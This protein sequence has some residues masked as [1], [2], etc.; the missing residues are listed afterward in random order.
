F[1]AILASPWCLK[2][3]F[4]FFSD[5]LPLA[6]Y[7]R[8]SYLIVASLVA[9]TSFFAL[10]WWTPWPTGAYSELL[11][12]LLVPTVAVIF[13]NV[14]VDAMMIEAGQPRGI[15]G[16]LQS[17][18][19]AAIYAGSILTGKMGGILSERH[20]QRLGFLICGCL[21]SATFLLSLVGV[22]ETR[23]HVS[24]NEGREAL[25]ALWK[26]LRSPGMLAVGAFTFLWYFNPFCQAV[27]YLHMTDCLGFSEEFYG[28]TMSLIAIGSLAA[29][30]SYGFYCRRVPMRRMVYLAVGLGLAS[31]WAYWYV[32]DRASAA[33]VSLLTGFSYMT[34]SMILVDLAARACPMAAAGT[35][36]A[37]FMAAC[38]TSSAITTWLGGTLY[39]A[40]GERWGYERGFSVVIGLGGLFCVSSGWAIRFLPAHL[41]GLPD[42][43]AEAPQLSLQELPTLAELPLVMEPNQP[44][45]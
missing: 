16:R 38:N 8:K 5:F 30:V 3:V 28:D 43:A 25:A 23:A 26:A 31:T 14:V 4:G 19:W 24:R 35:M 40:A 21:M 34:A 27:I 15:T 41:L 37:L 1:L 42:D 6:G 33:A 36:F 17:V 10:A 39:Q 20:E 29:C 9:M 18:Q 22:R 2:P 44:R 11:S 32:T 12:W 7:R 45:V 13:A